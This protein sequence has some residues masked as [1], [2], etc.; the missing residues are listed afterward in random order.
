MRCCCPRARRHPAVS[1]SFPCKSQSSLLIR[2][3]CTH[4]RP[5]RV[6]R[7]LRSSHRSCH[8]PHCPHQDSLIRSHCT[9]GADSAHAHALPTHKCCATRKSRIFLCATTW[10]QWPPC[11]SHAVG[12]T[13]AIPP[14]RGAAVHA[15]LTRQRTLTAS[16]LRAAALHA[17]AQPCW[18]CWQSTAGAAM[19]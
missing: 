11:C 16:F 17:P 12:D 15:W 9:A 10:D 7:H 14:Q 19:L 13:T 1:C 18:V 6:H 2:C 5:H 3:A 4:G 8:V